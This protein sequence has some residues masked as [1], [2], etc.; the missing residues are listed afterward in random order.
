VHYTPKHGSW[1]NQA[2]IE[3]SR[4]SRQCLGKRRIPEL[5][6][7]RQHLRAWTR[8]MNCTRVKINWKFT[9]R[10]EVAYK[11]RKA[12][13]V[14][15][16]AAVQPGEGGDDRMLLLTAVEVTDGVIEVELAGEPG[17]GASSTL[18]HR[19]RQ[20]KAR[21]RRSACRGRQKEWNLASP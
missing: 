3:I 16:A 14:V 19:C 5:A 10:E 2:E 1:L 11:G 6:V 12:L 20:K 18:R 9:R 13:R 21:C 15:D 8:Q 7:L 17:P 4:F